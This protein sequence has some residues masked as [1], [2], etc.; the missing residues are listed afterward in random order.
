VSRPTGCEPPAVNGVRRRSCTRAGREVRGA[1]QSNR[2]NG[3][4]AGRS[5]GFPFKFG[6]HFLTRRRRLRPQ[7][8]GAPHSSFGTSLNEPLCSIPWQAAEPRVAF[9]P[10]TSLCQPPPAPDTRP[11]SAHPAPASAAPA[12]AHRTSP[13]VVSAG[14]MGQG[15]R[16]HTHRGSAC[17]CPQHRPISR[18]HNHRQGGVATVSETNREPTNAT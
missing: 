16:R 2:T 8:P 14:R 13:P 3:A 11:W 9:P 7:Q 10:R 4:S 15:T 17:V 18:R 5:A 1:V 12:P 6:F